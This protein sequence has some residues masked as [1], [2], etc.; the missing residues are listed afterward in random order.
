MQTVQEGIFGSFKKHHH[1]YQKKKKKKKIT[2]TKSK[3][4]TD[5][6][7]ISSAYHYLYKIFIQV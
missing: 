3:V 6:Q 2:I 7:K 4:Q 5:Q 1:P